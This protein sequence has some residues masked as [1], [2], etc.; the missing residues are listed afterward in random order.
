MGNIWPLRPIEW[1]FVG[2]T[3]YLGAMRPKKE[4]TNL[5]RLANS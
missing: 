1:I 3:G 2:Y 5:T 4:A